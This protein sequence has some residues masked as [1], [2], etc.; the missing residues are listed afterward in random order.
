MNPI[1]E[2]SFAA[3]VFENRNRDFGGYFLRK[4]YK[5][6]IL[7]ALGLSLTGFIAVLMI[8][9]LYSKY[10]QPTPEPKIVHMV[11]VQLQEIPPVEQVEIPLPPPPVAPKVEVPKVAKV[12]FL[13][14][15]VAPDEEVKQED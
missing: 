2:K 8:P 4:I 3:L 14:P 5:R 7:L 1:L 13:P 11:E 10:F 9:L 12:K 6:N 15:K